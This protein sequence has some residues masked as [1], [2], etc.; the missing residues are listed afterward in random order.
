MR[1]SA[2]ILM[3]GDDSPIPLRR[4]Q[5]RKISNMKDTS[6]QG[7]NIV[8]IGFMGAGKTSL[9]KAVSKMLGVPFLDTDELIEQ[10]E[11][12]TISEIFEKKGEVCFRSL[13]TE[14]VRAL[15]DR[16]G[17]FVLSV[18]GGLPLR[19]ENRPLLHK[20]GCVV[21]L[22]VSIDTLEKRL[23]DDTKRPLLHQGKGTLREKIARILAQREPLYLEAADVVVVNEHKTFR[24][25]AEEVAALAQALPKAGPPEGV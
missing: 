10:S 18:G 15:A 22:Q 24:E 23:G 13:E 21:Y 19:E 9:G 5:S 3:S 4:M 14:T 20:A 11:G 17:G 16:E 2:R 7:R 6:Y 1:M 12:M 25:A 8:L